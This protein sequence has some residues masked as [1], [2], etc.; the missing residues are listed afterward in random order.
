MLCGTEGRGGTVRITEYAGHITPVHQSTWHTVFGRERWKIRQKLWY[1]SVLQ[2]KPRFS[3]AGQTLPVWKHNGHALLLLC[4]RTTSCCLRSAYVCSVKPAFVL[5]HSVYIQHVCVF[6][7][8]YIQHVCVCVCVCVCFT[9]CIYS[10]CVCFTP[11][12]YSMCVCV[13]VCV[14]VFHSVYIQHVCVCVCVFI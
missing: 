13:C 5:L 14:C 2:Y 6:H 3:Y 12:I 1:S 4:I 9:P 11:C 10:M 8:V 7:S